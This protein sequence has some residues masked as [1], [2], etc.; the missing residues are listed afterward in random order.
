[1]PT[2][3]LTGK[4]TDTV[5]P[6]ANVLKRWPMILKQHADSDSPICQRD[7]APLWFLILTQC[8]LPKSG[9]C[10]L[11]EREYF[12]SWGPAPLSTGAVDN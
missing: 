11:D 4:R 9:S 7:D 1:M 5:T 6:C 8:H 3:M 12:V 2:D 10:V